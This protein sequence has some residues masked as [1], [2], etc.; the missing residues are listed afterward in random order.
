M[1]RPH[2]LPG[3]YWI[4]LDN[5]SRIT[6]VDT[7]VEGQASFTVGFGG[8]LQITLDASLDD[9]GVVQVTQLTGTRDHLLRAW[10]NTSDAGGADVDEIIIDATT[11]T[12]ILVQPTAT[13]GNTQV[14]ITYVVGGTPRDRK[15]LEYLCRHPAGDNHESGI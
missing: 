9:K 13:D 4:N 2:C 5:I 6:H 10:L 12:D 11:I 1:T 14:Q 7:S 8:D 3:D 15:L